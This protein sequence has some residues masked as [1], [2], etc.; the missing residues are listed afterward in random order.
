M[1]QYPSLALADVYHV[2]AYSLRHVAN[3]ESYLAQR[4]VAMRA[5]RERNEEAFPPVG[6]REKLLARRRS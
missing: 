3:V 1:E 2:I 6:I 4:G 5:T